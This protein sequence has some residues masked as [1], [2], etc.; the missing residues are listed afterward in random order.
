[1]LAWWPIDQ[2]QMQIVIVILIIIIQLGTRISSRVITGV[3][4]KL[5]YAR[6]ERGQDAETLFLSRQISMV[7][8][9]SQRET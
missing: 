7:H 4:V 5:E 1:M 3:V 2:W 6:R 9:Q 8:M